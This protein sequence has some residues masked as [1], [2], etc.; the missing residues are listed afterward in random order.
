[1]NSIV[2]DQKSIYRKILNTAIFEALYAKW[3]IN[4]K[5]LGLNFVLT[6]WSDN[7]C[8]NKNNIFERMYQE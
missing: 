4:A 5:A 6:D 3:I 2:G 7:P 8:L 1:V